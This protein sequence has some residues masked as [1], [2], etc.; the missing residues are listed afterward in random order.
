MR[1][2]PMREAPSAA[3]PRSPFREREVSRTPRDTPRERERERERERSPPRRRESSPPTGPRGDRDR[4]FA[5]PTGPSSSYRNGD[6]GFSRAPPTGPSSRSYPSPAMSPPAGPAN[7]A[8]QAP[9]YP[10]GNNPVLAAPTRPRGGGRGGFGYDSPR[11]FNGPPSRRG[12]WGGGPRG[13]G[14]YGGPPSGP[15]GPAPGPTPFS[16][17]FR[18]SSNATA[19][20]YPRTM[21][22][23]DHLSDLP[24]EIPGGQRAPE[25][26]DKSKI[27]KLEEEARKLRELIDKKEDAKRAR[28]REWT[29]LEREAETAQ[30]RVELAEGSLR[31]LN[32]EGEAGGPAF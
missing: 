7:T 23:R 27:L 24:K 18:G 29:G 6:S 26:Y 5:P 14:Y 10:R 13:G 1:D 8:P 20:T 31:N 4:D 21:R 30:V 11:D 15:R 16:A 19:T 2:A 32:D 3:P 12:S 28:L 25:V 17:N 22:F 9:S